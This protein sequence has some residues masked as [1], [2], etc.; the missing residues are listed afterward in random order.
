MVIAWEAGGHMVFGRVQCIHGTAAVK[1]WGTDGNC[2]DHQQGADSHD[3]DR[4][5]PVCRSRSTITFLKVV[6]FYARAELLRTP[7]QSDALGH[8]DGTV[9]VSEEHC[10]RE[11]EGGTSGKKE[12]EHSPMD[13]STRGTDMLETMSRILKRAV[14]FVIARKDEECVCACFST[15]LCLGI[16]D[17]HTPGPNQTYR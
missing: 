12:K 14:V 9:R 17:A 7:Q 13:H 6:P 1:K 8:Y 2:A 4:Q 5:W 16:K 3:D 10:Q 11:Q 15:K